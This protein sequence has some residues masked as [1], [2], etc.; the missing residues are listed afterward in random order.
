MANASHDSH[1]SHGAHGGTVVD[2][3]H[4]THVSG[5]STFLRVYGAL[6][7]LTIITVAASRVDF[8]PAN[9]LIAVAIATV[10]ASL[11]MTFFMHLK[12][13]TAMNNIAFIGSFIF[14]SLLFLFTMADVA[15]RGMAEPLQMSPFPL[16]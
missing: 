3:S 14:L 15:T 8:G 6:C 9:M 16:N 5:F 10:K 12:W 4:H 11:V 13:D 1:D 7:F 2:H